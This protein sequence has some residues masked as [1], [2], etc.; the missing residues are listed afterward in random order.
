ME[1]ADLDASAHWQALELPRADSLTACKHA[2][3]LFR[4]AQALPN[5]AYPR[6]PAPLATFTTFTTACFGCRSS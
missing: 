2:L 5:T 6:H 3:A 1:S 4:A